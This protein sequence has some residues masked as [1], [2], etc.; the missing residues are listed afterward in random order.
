MGRVILTLPRLGETMEEAK[1]TEWLV[2][3][4]AVY[5][6][7][8]VLLEVETDKTVVEVPALAAGTL[9]KQLVAPGDMVELDAPIAEVEQ[10]GDVSVAGPEPTAPIPTADMP[11]PTKPAPTP[12]SAPRDA[13][14]RIAASPAARAEARRRGVS[15]S[16]MSGSGRR[17]RITADDVGGDDDG[18]VVL[19]HGLFDNSTGWRGL[20]QR[21]ARRGLACITLDLPGHGTD[22][23]SADTFDQA[24]ALL[25]DRLPIGPLHLVGHSLG[26]ALAARL[27]TRIGARARSLT[28]FAP[29]GLG[30]AISADFLTGMAQASSAE[31]LK[32]VL[33]LLDGGPM[34][35]AAIA[36][37][38]PQHLAGLAVRSRLAE[39][40]ARDGRQ[41][42]DATADIAA[43]PC[44]VTVVFGT[45]DRILDWRDVAHLPAETRIHLIPNAGHLP[46]L[47]RPDLAA[48]LI[49][50][51]HDPAETA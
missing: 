18:T 38:L 34:S 17:G 48:A 16:G 35:D 23:T 24:A 20:P 19:I 15:L 45:A 10:E 44:P 46:H 5:A 37:Q 1:V 27:A 41:Q 32:T 29:A 43:A 36:Q 25:A 7:G 4:G 31:A 9:L 50:P 40:V 49:A 47:V 3:I 13:S 39:A 11:A 51:R 26:A 2:A 22:T 12:P 28:L 42:I 21:M 33:A 30:A 8:D 14:G 6:R